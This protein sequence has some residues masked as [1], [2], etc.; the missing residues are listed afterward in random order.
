[1]KVRKETITHGSWEAL[2][3]CFIDKGLI[4][5]I[6]LIKKFFV[7][8]MN[9]LDTMEQYVNM[10]RMMVKEP[11]VIKTGVPSEVKVMVFFISFP[12][13]YQHFIRALESLKPTNYTWDNVCMKLPNE[14][15]M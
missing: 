3:K 12:K 11:D 1:M 4:N 5:K 2:A 8:Q 15:L 10:L 7:S 9:P 13:S 14:K 6:F